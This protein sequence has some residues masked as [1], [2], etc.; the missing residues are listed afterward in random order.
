MDVSGVEPAFRVAERESGARLMQ[1][2][3]NALLPPFQRPPSQVAIRRVSSYEEDLFEL[4]YETLCE[5]A[6]HERSEENTKKSGENLARNRATTLL[7]KRP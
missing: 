5:F 2:P 3:E 4:I 7:Y 1:T 6:K